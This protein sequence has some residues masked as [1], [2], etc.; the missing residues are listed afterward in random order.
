VLH[1]FA[2][3]SKAER[4]LG[5]SPRTRFPDGIRQFVAWFEEAYA[6]Q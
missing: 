6:R 3:V 2:D 4:M 5:Y 1:T